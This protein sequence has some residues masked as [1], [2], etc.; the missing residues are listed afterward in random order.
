MSASLP[1]LPRRGSA[2]FLGWHIVG[3]E[4]NRGPHP[5]QVLALCAETGRVFS[6]PEPRK[7]AKVPRVVYCFR[8]FAEHA[9]TMRDPVATATATVERERG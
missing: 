7:G 8:C 6:D 9:L 4:L 5:R 1:P 2:T 3:D